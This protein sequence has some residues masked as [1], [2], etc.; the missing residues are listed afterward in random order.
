MVV[1]APAP[2]PA[3]APDLPNPIIPVTSSIARN[4]ELV[5]NIIGSTSQSHIPVNAPASPTDISIGEATPL[6]NQHKLLYDQNE[7]YRVMS[8]CQSLG[9]QMAALLQDLGVS[10]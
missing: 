7:M 5:Q 9:K 10:E 1:D 6:L 2:F 8:I 3:V 4:V